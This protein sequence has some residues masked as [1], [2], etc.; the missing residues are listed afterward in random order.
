MGKVSSAHGIKGQIK[1]ICHYSTF[2][3]WQNIS[4]LY[5]ENEDCYTVTSYSITPKHIIISLK[6]IT[7]RNQAEALKDLALYAPKDDLSILEPDTYYYDDL[8]GLNAYYKGEDLAGKV[9]NVD[10]FGAGDLLEIE[11]NKG[12]TTFY[13]PFHNNF[14]QNIDLKSKTII[15]LKMEEQTSSNCLI[16]TVDGPSASGKG[17]IANYLAKKLKF[18]YLDT[19]LMY[20]MLAYNTLQAK[21]SLDDIP[22]IAKLAEKIDYS[23]TIAEEDKIKYNSEEVGQTAS[24]IAQQQRIRDV[25]NKTQHNFPINKKGVV[26]DGRDIGTVIFPHAKIK[27]YITASLDARSTRRFLQYKKTIPNISLEQVKEKLQERDKR[28]TMRAAS[29]LIIPDDAITID[30]SDLTV[31]ESCELAYNKIKQFLY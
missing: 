24:I 16:I 30:S 8:I 6:E 10:N 23:Q 17:T 20:R 13:H 14:I 25:L 19:G 4:H 18:D 28:D 2:N 3:D 31:E 21:I 15:L 9:V 5:S 12:K 22:S 29:P 26:I 1:V 11:P 27:L 7:N